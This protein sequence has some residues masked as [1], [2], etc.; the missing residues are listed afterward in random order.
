MAQ[1]AP[2]GSMAATLSGMSSGIFT[3]YCKSGTVIYS[4]YLSSNKKP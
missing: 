3:R 1:R 2:V 4:A